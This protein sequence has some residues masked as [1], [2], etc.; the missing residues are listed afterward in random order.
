[1]RLT[2]I[3]EPN[4][5][6]DARISDEFMG[7]YLNNDI[8]RKHVQFAVGEDTAGRV[9]KLWISAAICLIKANSHLRNFNRTIEVKQEEFKNSIEPGSSDTQRYYWDLSVEVEGLLT[10]LKAALDS[11]AVIIGLVTQQTGIRGWSKK[12]PTDSDKEFSGQNIINVLSR[13]LPE[14]ELEKY[15]QLI[16]WIEQSKDVLT[17]MVNVRDK[18]TH[19]NQSFMDFISGFYHV[20]S[21]GEIREPAIKVGKDWR[22]QSQY[23]GQAFDY[24]FDTLFSSAHLLLN[25]VAGGMILVKTEQSYGW[26]IDPEAVEEK[27]S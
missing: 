8:S 9:Y 21:S 10:Q 26:V 20:A 11:F 1:M 18:F 23:I 17:D 16:D 4:D 12:R 7:I 3:T 13:N 14:E 24:V 6:N 19:P 22:L 15:K 5:E 25:G 2:Q 27:D